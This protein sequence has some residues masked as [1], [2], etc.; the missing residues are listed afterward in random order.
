MFDRNRCKLNEITKEIGMKQIGIKGN[1]FISWLK[2]KFQ[3]LFGTIDVVEVVEK[4]KKRKYAKKNMEFWNKGSRNSTEEST[5]VVK[6]KKD[7]RSTRWARKRMSE[8]Q[9][10][11]WANYS[12][13]RREYLLKKLQDAKRLAQHNRRFKKIE[14]HVNGGDRDTC[15]LAGTPGH[16]RCGICHNHNK[17]RY[18]CGCVYNKVGA[19]IS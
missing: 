14:Q 17:P 15:T 1:S 4:S 10:K 2:G 5:E 11:R 19:L 18:E 3:W 12:P 13:E 9:Q 6:P 8:S 16:T 7:G